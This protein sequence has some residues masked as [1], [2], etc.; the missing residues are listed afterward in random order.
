MKRNRAALIF[1]AKFIIL[2]LV[3]NTG[4]GLF[5]EFYMPLPD[6]LTIAVS[7]QTA[8]LISLFS[9]SPVL[10]IIQSGYVNLIRH[11]QSVVSV[12]EGC[13]SANVLIVHLSFI[14]S[15]HSGVART[16][17]FLLVT[18]IMLYAINLIRVVLLFETALHYPNYLYFIHKYLLTGGIYA[19]VFLMWYIWIKRLQ[20]ESTTH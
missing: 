3:L 9:E 13:N 10:A 18:S 7:R 15:F 2:Y 14:V 11:G 8:A 6:P 16:G 4:Y 1:I 19:F 20:R 12:Y 5:V 17:V